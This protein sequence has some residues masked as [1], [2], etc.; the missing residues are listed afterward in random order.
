MLWGITLVCLSLVVVPLLR[1][2][3][4]SLA[5]AVATVSVLLGS[6]NM[7]AP[8]AW[9][10]TILQ[11]DTFYHRIRIEE[12]DEAR[13][14]YFDRT[15]QSAMTLKDPAALRLTLLALHID[16]ASHSG[17]TPRKC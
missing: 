10:K 3:R 17:R 15:L 4:I 2:Q 13:Y 6:V 12:D 5:R 8:M 7:W 9:A 1:L 14:M 11:K 16:W